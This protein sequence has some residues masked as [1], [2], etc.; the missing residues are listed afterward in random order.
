MPSP[1]ATERPSVVIL[2]PIKNAAPHLDRYAELVARLDWPRDRLSIG[3]MEGDSTDDTYV[4]A[5]E[6][7]PQLERRC[8]R[9]TLLKRDF[10]F[11]MPAGAPRWTPA[12]QL[13]RRS[14]LAR[15]RN[16]LLFGA[17]GDEDWVLWIDVDVVEYPADIITR[18]LATRFDIVV[19]H[20]V[21]M[22]GGATFDQNNWS[23]RG[24][25]GLADRRGA[26]A[27][28]LDSVGGAMLLVKADLHRDGLVFPTFRYGV[29]S[30]RIRPTHPVWG[31][32]EIETEGLGI[33]AGDM[34]V[35]CWGLP[36]LEIL[37]ASC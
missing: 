16:H 12:F 15:A 17:L 23:E 10:S 18:L 24:T 34:G 26:G 3:L 8:R 33:M 20:C 29:E 27:M 6:L 30:E 31:K 13:A 19:P 1:D 37:H 14:V 28:R 7:L 2:T 11:Q 35:Q 21:T 22:P 4:K 5:L 25:L 36:D 32:G 9:A